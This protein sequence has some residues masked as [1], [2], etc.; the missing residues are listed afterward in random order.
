MRKTVVLGVLGSLAASPAV[1][2][3]LKILG[4]GLGLRNKITCQ[5]AP[6]HDGIHSC[7]D[8]ERGV[9][10]RTDGETMIKVVQVTRVQVLTADDPSPKD[11]V[12]RAIEHYGPPVAFDTETLTAT[13]GDAFDASGDDASG[14]SGQG[15]AI[16]V[17]AC[18]DRPLD[19]RRVV[20]AKSVVL[21]NLLDRGARDALR[22]KYEEE[23]Q[24]DED[25]AKRQK[26]D[27]M[28]F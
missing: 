27:G 1:A 15:L 18:D 20:G 7:Y 17:H 22:A 11:V 3:D 21:Y 5:L 13:F 2:D 14:P 26:L 8:A 9:A 25:A 4:T 19:C 6:A 12:Q 10:I 28:R 24:S 23:K 16:T